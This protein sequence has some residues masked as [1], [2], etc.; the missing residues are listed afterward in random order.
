M[1]VCIMAPDRVFLDIEA[2]EVVL[3]TTTGLVGIL[4]NHTPLVTGIGMGIMLLREKGEWTSLALLRGFAFVQENVVTI[5][6]NEAE[7]AKNIDADEAQAA[8]AEAEA[9]F[10][11]AKTKTE[12]YLAGVKRDRAR[13]RYQVTQTLQ[14]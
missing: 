1:K 2:E 14:G 4:E 3:P 6:V 7:F 9:E 8:Y 12:L 10:A 5:L 13:V 11:K